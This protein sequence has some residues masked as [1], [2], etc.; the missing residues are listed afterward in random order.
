MFILNIQ[1]LEIQ[2]VSALTHAWATA[3]HDYLYK[4]YLFGEAPY[5]EHVIFDALDGIIKTGD[6]LLEQ[7]QSMV[8]PRT[9]R[10]FES[11]HELGDCL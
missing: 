5:G 3:G 4:N 10:P 7:F 6:Q 8:Y 2:V 11:P 9:M 1:G